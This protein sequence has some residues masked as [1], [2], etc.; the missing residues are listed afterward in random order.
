MDNN[1]VEGLL[2]RF[3]RRGQKYF[4]PMRSTIVTPTNDPPFNRKEC[5]RMMMLHSF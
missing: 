3:K 1:T 4:M 2:A 5:T